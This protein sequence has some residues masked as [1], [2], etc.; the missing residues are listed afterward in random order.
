MMKI[1]IC[2]DDS[3]VIKTLELSILAYFKRKKMETPIISTFTSAESM[4]DAGESY[5]LAFLDVEM[6]GLTGISSIRELR[7]HNKN[8]L[9]FIVTS[10]DTSYLDE[11]LEEGIYRYMMKPV[12]PLQLQVNLTAAIRRM[13]TQSRKVTAETNQ[14]I[15]T[16]DTDEIIM[17]YTERRKTWIRTTGE[18]YISIQNFHFWEE[19]LPDFS[20]AVSHKGIL[21]HLKYVRK[22]GENLIDLTVPGEPVYLSVR[23]RALFKKKFLQYMNI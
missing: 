1:V 6:P 10:H 2:D 7:N 12:N 3:D 18:S 4:I 5:D 14:G 21:V 13:G 23:N 16:L 20:F 22:I 17:V 15:I 8:L 9:V 11:A 19:S